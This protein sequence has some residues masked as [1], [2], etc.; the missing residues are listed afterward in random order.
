SVQVYAL[1]WARP[2]RVDCMSIT[3]AFAFGFDP[4]FCASGCNTTRL[5][6]YFNSS[7]SHPFD[8]LDIRPAMSIAATNLVQAQ[9][10]IDRG[11]RADGSAPGG[12]AY[13]VT[14]GDGARDVRAAANGDVLMVAGGK[15][16]IVIVESAGLQYRPDVMFYFTG[17]VRVPSIDTN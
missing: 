13:L 15:I 2:Y 12:T 14:S 4:R 8:Q 17:A 16:R 5:S 9:E 3:S 6:P 11:I 1:T 10:L 7:S